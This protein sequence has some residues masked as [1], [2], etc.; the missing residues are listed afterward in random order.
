MQ[1]ISD[2][3]TE[4]GDIRIIG[5]IN[6]MSVRIGEIKVFH[7]HGKLYVIY[8]KFL[9]GSPGGKAFIENLRKLDALCIGLM[10]ELRSDIVR[11]LKGKEGESRDN[12]IL[13]Y[14]SK[15]LDLEAI[16][17]LLRNAAIGTE[18]ELGMINY[19]EQCNRSKE[20]VIL[21][22]VSAREHEGCKAII[23]TLYC[24]MDYGPHSPYV[25]L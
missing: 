4:L 6:K 9:R 7:P 24:G 5:G 1:V 13:D 17:A 16:S 2:K 18:K 3:N 15:P 22:K 21:K 25:D 19:P 23:K 8:D 14:F 12:A 10:P 20:M 11:I